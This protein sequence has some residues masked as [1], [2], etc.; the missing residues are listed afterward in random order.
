MIE[1]Q[2]VTETV[3]QQREII[4]YKLSNQLKVRASSF[5]ALPI[6]SSLCDSNSP[7]PT[8]SFFFF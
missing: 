2:D 4:A 5:L 8:D 6:S 3:Q 1:E 7:T